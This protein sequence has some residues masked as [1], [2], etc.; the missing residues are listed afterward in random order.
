MKKIAKFPL[1]FYFLLGTLSHVI[2][3]INVNLWQ[4][5][6]FSELVTQQFIENLK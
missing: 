4:I 1:S 2:F 3:N 6:D 5:T